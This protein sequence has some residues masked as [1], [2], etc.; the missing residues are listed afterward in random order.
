MYPIYA[1][2]IL[3]NFCETNDNAIS[4]DQQFQPNARSGV[5][6]SNETKGKKVRHIL[7]KYFDP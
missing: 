4:Y 7:T 1:Y 2:F 3:H 6:P 5:A